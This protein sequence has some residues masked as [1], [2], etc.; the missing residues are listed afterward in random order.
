M[1][2]QLDAGMLSQYNRAKNL[3]EDFLQSMAWADQL[4][5]GS[6]L[7][8]SMRYSLLQNGKRFRPVLCLLTVEEFGVPPQRA[9][10]FAAALE[11]IHTYSLI[12]D[13]LPC[14]DDD[15][16]RRGQPTN[17]IEF[18]EAVALLAGDALQAEAFG[19]IAGS[20]STDP[21]MGLKLVQILAQACGVQGMVG[22]Q[23]L[24]IMTSELK[25]LQQTKTMHAMKTGALI[26]SACAGAGVILGLPENKQ[27]TL[28]QFGENLGLAFQIADDLLDSKEGD[29]EEGSYPALM[30]LEATQKALQEASQWACQCLND[31]GIN[32]GV[33]MDLVKFNAQRKI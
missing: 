10:P 32:S 5:Q 29:I 21:R 14:M 31:L 11:M 28:A 3:F 13:D 12:H 30:G 7:I 26:R 27:I 19:L 23:A 6:Q 8:E 15:D 25:N 4:N 22:G 1:S 17:H 16:L 20:Y 9:L 24:D 33:L 18:G 2:M